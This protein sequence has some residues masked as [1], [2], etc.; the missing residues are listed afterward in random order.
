LQDEYP[1][2][3]G[4]LKSELH[5]AFHGWSPSR[6]P[7]LR[8]LMERADRS[9]TRPIMVLS[10]AGA[11]ALALLLVAAVAVVLSAPHIPAME[12]IREH[13]LAP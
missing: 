8:D 13:L 4:E 3:D 5:R 12:T 9:W 10:T 1:H 2:G 7:D 6:G 11:A